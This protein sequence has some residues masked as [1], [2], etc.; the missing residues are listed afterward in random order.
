MMLLAATRVARF[1]GS[2]V[3]QGD[4]GNGLLGTATLLLGGATRA[5]LGL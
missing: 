5:R 2:L 4:V 3:A 1:G